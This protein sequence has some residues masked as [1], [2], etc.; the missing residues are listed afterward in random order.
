[1]EHYGQHLEDSK[2]QLLH[3]ADMEAGENFET[4]LRTLLHLWTNDRAG[5][6]ADHLL[7]Y[8]LTKDG[9]LVTTP[10]TP[11]PPSR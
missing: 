7:R 6:T 8:G 3:V 2:R 10:M 5:Q 4:A 1:M 9:H 11:P